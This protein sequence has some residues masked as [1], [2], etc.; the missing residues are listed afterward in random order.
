MTPDPK[1]FQAAKRNLRRT[2][3]KIIA[4][5]E[6]L[7]RDIEWWNE[8]RTDAA[9]FDVGGCIIAVKLAKEILDLVERD[10]YL[11]REKMLRLQE[12]LARNAEAT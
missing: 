7:R 11:P 12:Q 6:Q 8:N 5:T 10:Q 4:E 3:R 9:P 2:M 1:K